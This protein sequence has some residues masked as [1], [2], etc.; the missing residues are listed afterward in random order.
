MKKLIVSNYGQEN[1]EGVLMQGDV[2]A[3]VERLG[4]IIGGELTGMSCRL[5]SGSYPLV[6]PE[7][8]DVIRKY[9]NAREVE[10]TDLL[11]V[12][13]DRLRLDI[14]YHDSEMAKLSGMI[15][16]I[17]WESGVDGIV[18]VAPHLVTNG[19]PQYIARKREFP[20]SSFFPL[21]LKG[22]ALEL[23]MEKK[24]VKLIHPPYSE[25]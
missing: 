9:T 21:A 18:I 17:E 7:T 4:G 13:E 24:S 10:M 20:E 16:S 11:R 6:A 15:E 2:Y 1:H 3:S 8:A 25:M 22:Q 12:D 19:L 5:L 23:D 14:G